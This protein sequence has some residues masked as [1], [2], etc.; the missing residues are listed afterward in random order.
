MSGSPADERL[1]LERE[2]RRLRHELQEA[3]GALPYLR[4]M[5]QFS[6]DLLILA[7]PG[8]RILE[9]N[10]RLAVVLGVPQ[11]ELYGQP[12]QNWLPNPGQVGVPG[13]P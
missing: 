6:G 13:A 10:T 2:I 1:R 11:H 8:G 12:L 3:A 5:V 9:A 7:G 4:Q